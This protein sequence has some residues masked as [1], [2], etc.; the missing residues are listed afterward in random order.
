MNRKVVVTGGAGFIGSHLVRALLERGDDVHIIDNFY[1][2]RDENLADVLKDVQL[3]EADIREQAVLEQIFK[4]ADSVF[5]LAAV[6]SV[7][8]SVEQ[9]ELSHDVNI[10]GSLSV[11][12]AARQCQV[13]AISMA[14]SSSVYGD[15][16]TL[17]K[18]ESMRPRPLSPYA[19]Q[20]L[21]MET[22][23]D[24][25]ARCYD[26]QIVSLRY[27]NI[28]GPRQNPHS[29]YAAVIP[30][31]IDSLRRNQRPIIFG[32]G[33]QTRDFT[34][35]DNVV[36]ANL[37]ATAELNTRGQESIIVNIGNSQPTSVNELTRTIATILGKES[38]KPEYQD[39]RPG[40]VKHSHAAIEEAQ[41]RL[42]Y[43][44]QV[45]F[46]RGLEQTVSWYCQRTEK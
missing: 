11:L 37:L 42:N 25:F 34:H 35:V 29:A 10:N 16:L 15:T 13:R 18:R 17:P 41:E 20:K 27:F 12:F 33:E 36:Q 23:G 2:G 19:A 40:D 21:A 22:Y 44:P 14:S 43:Q 4:G 1:S 24:V 45:S 39:P 8:R 9:P 32:D 26:M 30:K 46:Q 6:P 31:F 7:P 38:I 5:H 28:F 3:H